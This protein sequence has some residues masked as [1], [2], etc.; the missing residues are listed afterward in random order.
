MERFRKKGDTV[1]SLKFLNLRES[2]CE[3]ALEI[4]QEVVDADASLQHWFDRALDFGRG[5]LVDAS[6]GTPFLCDYFTQYR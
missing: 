3:D 5:N 2:L 4:L 1:N 6:L